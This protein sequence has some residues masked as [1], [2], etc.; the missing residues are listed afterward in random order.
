VKGAEI[1]KELRL[2]GQ[3]PRD[4]IVYVDTDRGCR[5]NRDWMHYGEHAHVVVEPKDHL[6]T[7]DVRFAW[8][9]TVKVEGRNHARVLAV[10]EQFKPVACRVL[11]ATFVGDSWKTPDIFTDTLGV[12]CS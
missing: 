4:G 11:T 12:M 6:P 2:L 8:Q 10:A 3:V 1:L 9:L 5:W 7:L